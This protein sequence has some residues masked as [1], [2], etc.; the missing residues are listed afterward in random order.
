MLLLERKGTAQQRTNLA[1][2]DGSWES[3]PLVWLQRY[4]FLPMPPNILA[5]FL[6]F[7][8]MVRFT[9]KYAILRGLS[10]LKTANLGRF[11]PVLAAVRCHARLTEQSGDGKK[12]H[13]STCWN[14]LQSGDLAHTWQ[15]SLQSTSLT[16][17]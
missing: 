12:S 9:V 10:P 11:C 13:Y 17:Y 3:K 7:G 2:V 15:L 6:K 1:E 16:T 8:Q 4:A 14:C 5:I